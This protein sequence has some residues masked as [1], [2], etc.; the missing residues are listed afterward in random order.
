MARSTDGANIWTLTGNPSGTIVLDPFTPGT[1]Y[2]SS[3]NVLS[4]SSDNGQTFV[5]LPPLPDKA[6][7]LILTPDPKHQGVLFAGT[8]AGIY[9]SSDAGLVHLDPRRMR[10]S[11]PF[12]SPI[13]TAPRSMPA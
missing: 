3:S 13:Q 8:T 2:S 7:L 6:A 4:K 11:Q 5:P 10:Q 12:W 9:Q 1:L